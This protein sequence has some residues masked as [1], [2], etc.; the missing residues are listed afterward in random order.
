MYIAIDNAQ[1]RPLAFGSYGNFDSR[2]ANP[3][4]EAPRSGKPSVAVPETPLTC[5]PIRT[6][7]TTGTPYHHKSS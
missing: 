1:N 4:T 6:S 5:T 2:F 3:N 7:T